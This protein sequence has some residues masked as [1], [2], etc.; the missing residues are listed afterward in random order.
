MQKA[1]IAKPIMIKLL[2]SKDMSFPHF[3]LIFDFCIIANG[4]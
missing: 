4:W 1:A 3:I 2:K